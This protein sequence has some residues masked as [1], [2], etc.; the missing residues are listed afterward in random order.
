MILHLIL[1]VSAA[2]LAQ[3]QSTPPHAVTSSSTATVRSFPDVGTVVLGVETNATRPA[4]ASSRNAETASSIV[5]G[6]IAAG[7]PPASVVLSSASV[8]PLY[9]P[10]TSPCACDR[11]APVGYLAERTIR[12]TLTN[13][14]NTN[15]TFPGIQEIIATAF[16]A[17]ASSLSS[18][19]YSLGDERAAL[20]ADQALAGAT[21]SAVSHARSMLLGLSNGLQAVNSSV[22]TR[23]CEVLSVNQDYVQQPR[24]AMVPM[25]AMLRAAPGIGVEDDTNANPA[26]EVT[27]TASVSVSLGLC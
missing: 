22:S 6:L 17:G 10:S 24:A 20:A 3:A 8:Q 2:A 11:G 19:S 16:S 23:V 21:S 12:V 26:G 9:A 27:T 14:N 4:V 5:E 18:V 7:L 13:A 15:G 1:A 25:P